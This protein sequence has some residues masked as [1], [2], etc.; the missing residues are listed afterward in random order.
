MYHLVTA[1]DLGKVSLE[2]VIKLLH[3]L[4]LFLIFD[5]LLFFYQ[6]SYSPII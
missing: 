4:F 3:V 1:F 6:I 2:G 5:L